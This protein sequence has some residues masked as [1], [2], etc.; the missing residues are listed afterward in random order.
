MSDTKCNAGEIIYANENGIIF[1]TGQGA[2][3]LLEVQLEGKHRMKAGD[4]VRGHRWINR[5]IR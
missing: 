4:F 3:A 2:L 5:P 1:A